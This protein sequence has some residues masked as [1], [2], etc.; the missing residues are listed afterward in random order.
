[1]VGKVII[2]FETAY[3]GLLVETNKQHHN[4]SMTLLYVLGHVKNHPAAIVSY[5]YLLRK[6]TN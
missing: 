5:N 1:M 3:I 6:S 2:A 4:R